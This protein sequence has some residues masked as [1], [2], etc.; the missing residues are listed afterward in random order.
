M[1]ADRDPLAAKF[2]ALRRPFKPSD[3]TLRPVVDDRVPREERVFGLCAPYGPDGG[4]APLGQDHYCGEV[5]RL[6]ARHLHAVGHAA[7]TERLL[8][9]DPWWSW[10]PMAQT[11]DG[12]PALKLTTI[13]M[14]N[15]DTRIVPV[16]MWGRLRVLGVTRIGYGSCSP[17]AYE[18]EKELIGDMIRN[19]AMRF[20][21]AT[22]LWR[23]RAGELDR[24]IAADADDVVEAPPV[25]AR[26]P[27]AVKPAPEWS[28]PLPMTAEE[29]MRC[30]LQDLPTIL[31]GLARAQVTARG[32]T[33]PLT[34]AEAHLWSDWLRGFLAANR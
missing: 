24:L 19:A 18:P 16:G 25:P 2:R 10:E 4:M 7:V 8:D 27:A 22:Y 32:W 5:H 20:G 31:L 9:V 13:E 3:I 30:E 15:G 26:K 6:P 12:V 17:W 23:G 29:A 28:E 1:T 14:R 33:W 21:V 34:L 11:E